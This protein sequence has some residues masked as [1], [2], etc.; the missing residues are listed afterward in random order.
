MRLDELFWNPKSLLRF[1]VTRLRI[2]GITNIKCCI[3]QFMTHQADLGLC[4]SDIKSDSQ[5]NPT[6]YSNPGRRTC[7][8]KTCFVKNE[9]RDL[10]K[11]EFMYVKI[12]NLSFVGPGAN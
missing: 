7:S 9:C 8:E 2:I 4:F 3:I 12:P 10:E 11:I 6:P 1:D 5:P